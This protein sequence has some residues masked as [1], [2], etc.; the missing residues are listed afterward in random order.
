MLIS[1][2]LAEANKS[3]LKEISPE[4]S[5]E[6]LMLKLK[7]QYC[8]HLMWRTDYW[9]RP[10]CWERLKVKEKGAPEEEM[11]GWHHRLYG[12]ESEEAPGVGDGQ[13]SLA[14]CSPWS[15]KESDTTELLNWIRDERTGV[16]D[17][18]RKGRCSNPLL[19]IRWDSLSALPKNK[20]RS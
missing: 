7:L 11:V 10:W 2:E 9:K 5:L 13:G 8:G 15:C 6:G 14:R 20:V 3:I 4:Y 19:W 17:S 1:D 16:I 18:Q 12:H